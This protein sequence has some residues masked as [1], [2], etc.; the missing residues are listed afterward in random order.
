MRK[1]WSMGKDD[2]MSPCLK[3]SIFFPFRKTEHNLYENAWAGSLSYGERSCV[4]QWGLSSYL[5][6]WQILKLV[7]DSHL[8]ICLLEWL[9]PELKKTLYFFFFFN[10]RSFRWLPIP[11]LPY[12]PSADPG[13]HSLTGSRLQCCLQRSAKKEFLLSALKGWHPW[14]CYQ[15]NQFQMG[16]KKA[17]GSNILFEIMK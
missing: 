11:F 10:L 6:W 16:A 8:Y 14:F 9:E 12:I 17:K 5:E 15:G 2:P 7:A 4:D 13:N 1:H 3:F